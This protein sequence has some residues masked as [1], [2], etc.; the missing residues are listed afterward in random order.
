MQARQERE[1]LRA[2]S[3]CERQS[4]V[5]ACPS[6]PLHEPFTRPRSWPIEV[7]KRSIRIPNV[8]GQ[9]REPCPSKNSLKVGTSIVDVVTTHKNPVHVGV[10]GGSGLYNLGNL[11][12]VS[13]FYTVRTDLTPQLR[14]QEEG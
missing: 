14:L 11:T 6:Q 8:L 10:I 13:V 2:E 1:G 9:E 7:E 4:N 5:A 12:L 3:K